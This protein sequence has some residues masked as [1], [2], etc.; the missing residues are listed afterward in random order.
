MPSAWTS[1][2]RG[3]RPVPS[4]RER[5]VPSV[6]ERLGVAAAGLGGLALALPTIG[7]PTW[8]MAV[9][10]PGRGEVLASQTTWSW[11]KVVVT[12]RVTGEVVSETVVANVPGLVGLV[13]MLAAGFVGLVVWV[14]LPGVRGAVAGL[15]GVAVAASGLVT[16]TL[17]RIGQSAR[18]DAYRLTGL[19]VRSYPQ[20]AAVYETL[21][22][23][24]LVG[25]LLVMAWLILRAGSPRVPAAAAARA[26]G[27]SDAA[28]PDGAAPDGA[29]SARADTEG[30]GAERA[31]TERTALQ[32]SDAIPQLE[33][34][35]RPRH[36][37]SEAVSFSDAPGPGRSEQPPPDPHR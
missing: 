13:A 5:V 19:D 4:M 23:L 18:V 28:A 9:S 32:G 20:P 16:A 1:S 2:T 27:A 12:G 30:A 14:A 17:Q 37:T 29:S 7:S 24:A 25:T 22:T 34:D 11:G 6:T 33:P 3:G 35:R 10:D 31:G 8:R 21:S 26:G 15:V 36:L